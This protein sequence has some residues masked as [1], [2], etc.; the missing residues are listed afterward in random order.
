MYDFAVSF[1]GPD[2][3]WADWIAV[4]LAD[5]GGRVLL[6]EA[7]RAGGS[8]GPDAVWVPLISSSSARQREA[9]PDWWWWDGPE[10]QADPQSR[11][12]VVDTAGQPDGTQWLDLVALSRE[13]DQAQV[14]GALCEY[15]GLAPGQG[16]HRAAASGVSM[17]LYPPLRPAV[18]NIPG[19]NP[20]FTGRQEELARVRDSFLTQPEVPCVVSGPAGVGK[21]S[22]AIEYAYQYRA[23]YRGCWWADGELHPDS[24]Q[25]ELLSDPGDAQPW[26]L[27]IDDADRPARP[28]GT[29]AQ[30]TCHVLITS[31]RPADGCRART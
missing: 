26:L 2:R 21:T 7:G 9:R 18:W 16:D 8:P 24:P 23:H 4:V 30:G 10:G 13:H 5:C 15:L 12:V 11:P 14:T 25:D 3:A 17:P 29:A 19:R 1:F 22:L 20:H 6:L 31:G 27:I 28:A